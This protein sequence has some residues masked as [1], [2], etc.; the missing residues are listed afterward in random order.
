MPLPPRDGV[1]VEGS[2]ADPDFVQISWPCC[3]HGR[4]TY[5]GRWSRLD[6]MVDCICR[7]HP[8]PE[9]AELRA[10]LHALLTR[11]ATAHEAAVAR[12]KY[13]S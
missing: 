4:H 5:S 2:D 1:I 12:Q 6:E 9:V 8:I 10:G 11:A 3:V 13:Y 7:D